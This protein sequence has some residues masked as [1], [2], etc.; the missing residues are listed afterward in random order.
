[1]LFLAFR[2]PQDEY[3]KNF[4]DALAALSANIEELFGDINNTEYINAFDE[5]KT[6]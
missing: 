1:M 6:I 3:R 4:F 5:W 2:I